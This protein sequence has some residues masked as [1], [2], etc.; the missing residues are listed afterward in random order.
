MATQEGDPISDGSTM[1]PTRRTIRVQMQRSDGTPINA[2]TL[3]PA[4]RRYHEREI[5]SI[6]ESFRGQLGQTSASGSGSGSASASASGSA[7]GA[8]IQSEQRQR[9]DRNRSGPSGAGATVLEGPQMMREELDR[10]RSIRH[11]QQQQQQQQLRL[12][13]APLHIQPLPLPEQLRVE[14]LHAQPLPLPVPVFRP[15]TH[16][17]YDCRV[18]F[19][20]MD[21]PA[22]CGSPRCDARFCRS[23]LTRV[24]EGAAASLGQMA[25]VMPNASLASQ[26]EGAVGRCPCCRAPFSMDDVIRDGALAAKMGREELTSCPF[27]NCGKRLELR[28]VKEHEA[29][30]EYMPMRCRFSAFGCSWTGPRK[31]VDQHEGIGCPYGRIAPLVEHSRSTRAIHAHQIRQ[32][33]RQLS[34]A[35]QEL[36]RQ[37]LIIML[38]QAKDPGSPLDCME[39]IILMLTYR[40]KLD[41]TQPIWDKFRDAKVKSRLVNFFSMTST[42]ALLVKALKDLSEFESELP[43]H[44]HLDAIVSILQA[45]GLLGF[46]ALACFCV[47]KDRGDSITWSNYNV[48]GT[49]RSWPFL[50]DIAAVSHFAIVFFSLIGPEGESTNLLSLRNVAVLAGTWWCMFCTSLV[51]ECIC[52]TT[53]QNKTRSHQPK[54]CQTVLFG[55][56]YGILFSLFRFTTAPFDG[57]LLLCLLS[58]VLKGRIPTFVLEDHSTCFSAIGMKSVAALVVVRLASFFVMESDRAIEDLKLAL[59]ATVVLASYNLKNAI[60]SKMAESLVEIRNETIYPTIMILTW[61][62]ALSMIVL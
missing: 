4:E 11:Q 30:C 58:A 59:A 25:A 38:T 6:L 26:A 3:T 27:P 34:A 7:S 21:D 44:Q 54:A 28:S 9:Q 12:R 47:L 10:I 51:C 42:I 40:A 57:M 49:S 8:A 37:S 43:D 39:Y 1:T 60:A 53:P 50:R 24:W 41:K 46:M 61:L 45:M 18:C 14:P 17:A 22:G 62:G 2:S 29:I 56:R 55:L 32:L 16:P 31:D 52:V 23:C 33:H 36:H 5:A 20:P 13:V 48:L 15:A 35:Q 19:E